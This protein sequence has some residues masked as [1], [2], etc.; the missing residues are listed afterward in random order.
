MNF[1]RV[2]GSVVVWR[3]SSSPELPPHAK[4]GIAVHGAM[5]VGRASVFAPNRFRRKESCAG[6][7]RGWLRQMELFAEHLK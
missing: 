2:R 3:T 5:L 6:R 4:A 1:L 7:L